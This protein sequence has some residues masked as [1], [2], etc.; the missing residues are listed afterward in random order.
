MFPM[1]YCLGHWLWIIL[2][3]SVSSWFVLAYATWVWVGI[4]LLP[5]S[6]QSYRS[7]CDENLYRGRREKSTK[8]RY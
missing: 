2:T 4:I 5:F 7:R 8:F 1:V 6:T 3:I